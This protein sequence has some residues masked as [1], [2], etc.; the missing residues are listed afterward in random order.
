M[1]GYPRGNVLLLAI[2]VAA[3]LGSPSNSQGEGVSVQ[4]RTSTICATLCPDSSAIINND[5]NGLSTPARCTAPPLTV[6]GSYDEIRVVVPDAIVDGREPDAVAFTIYPELDY[7]ATACRVRSPGTLDEAYEVAPHSQVLCYHWCAG[8]CTFPIDGIGCPERV[9]VLVE[10]G[11]TYALRVFNVADV[12]A[13]G[14]TYRFFAYPD[15]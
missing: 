8:P 12:F 1:S 9:V 13:V 10:P 15:A 11:E 6:P 7:D 2:A 14:G 3:V 5:G 4:F